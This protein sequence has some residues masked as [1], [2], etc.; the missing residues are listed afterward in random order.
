[1]IVVKMESLNKD[2]LTQGAGEVIDTLKKY[3]KEY[4]IAIL[5]YLM[6]TFPEEYYIIGLDVVKK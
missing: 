5:H 3:D 2:L 6:D 4:K 1:M